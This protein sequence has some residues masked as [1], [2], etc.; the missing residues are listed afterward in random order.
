ETLEF[1][2]GREDGTGEGML[3]ALP[4][5]EEFRTTRAGLDL[6]GELRLQA[7]GALTVLPPSRHKSGRPYE[8]KAGRGPDDLG[9]A[10]APAWLIEALRR[11]GRAKGEVPPRPAGAVDEA[12]KALAL[13]ALAGL[14]PA[15]AD[16]YDSW[17][18]TGMVLHSIDPSEEMLEVWDR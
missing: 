3:Y 11:S 17:V 1:T 4:E 8:W 10:Q 16:D 13:A 14:S 15:R 6:G 2:S 12:T 9:V 5:G 18:G 7:L